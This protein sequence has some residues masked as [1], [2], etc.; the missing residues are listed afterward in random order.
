MIMLEVEDRYMWFVYIVQCSD[1]TLYTG[2]TNDLERRIKQHNDGKG[3]RYTSGR[4]PVKLVRSFE[5]EN[6]SAA[7]KLEYKIKQLP[8]EKKLTYE[9]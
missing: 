6:K 3:A 4:R 7:L 8:R 1:E 2:S 9:Q 5:V